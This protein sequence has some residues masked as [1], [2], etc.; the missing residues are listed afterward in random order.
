MIEF[1]GTPQIFT[2]LKKMTICQIANFKGVQ[3]NEILRFVAACSV[4][5]GYI[6]FY[7]VL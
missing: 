2:Q 7:K 6:H 1:N 3:N 4:P 5:E